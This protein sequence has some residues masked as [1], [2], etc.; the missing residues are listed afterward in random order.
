[1]LISSY[2]T[3]GAFGA[4][5][6]GIGTSQVAQVFAR[7]EKS[8]ILNI[9]TE[10]LN[11]ILPKSTKLRISIIEQHSQISFCLVTRKVKFST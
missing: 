4:I 11:K 2:R 3:H 8:D 6:F 7:N 5:A 9:R 10:E 1:M